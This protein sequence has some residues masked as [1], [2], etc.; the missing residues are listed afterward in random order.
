LHDKSD[1]GIFHQISK[2]KESLSKIDQETESIL[3]VTTPMLSQRFRDL[4]RA[5]RGFGD[6]AGDE[7]GSRRNERK[8]KRDNVFTSKI[9]Q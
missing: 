8:V 3:S 5:N 6:A 2:S 7:E 4:H 1:W 9:L